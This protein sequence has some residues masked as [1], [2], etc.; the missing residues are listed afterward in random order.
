MAATSRDVPIQ[1]GDVASRA[2]VAVTASNSGG[3]SQQLAE[4]KQ[5]LSA[6]APDLLSANNE[7]ASELLSDGEKCLP[8]LCKLLQV[9]KL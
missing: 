3:L 4:L 7:Q 6:I 1:K 5:R 9:G 2:H 8:E